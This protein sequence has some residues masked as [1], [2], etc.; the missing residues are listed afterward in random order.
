[1]P[2]ASCTRTKQEDTL[3]SRRKGFHAAIIIYHTP[4]TRLHILIAF[5]DAAAPRCKR[6]FHFLAFIHNHRDRSLS[7]CLQISCH[8]SLVVCASTRDGEP[9]DV[10]HR[11]V[12]AGTNPRLILLSPPRR[13]RSTLKELA[14]S[15]HVSSVPN[16]TPTSTKSYSDQYQTVQRSADLQNNRAISTKTHSDEQIYKTAHRSADLQNH[17]AISRSTKLHSDQHKAAQRSAQNRIAI[18]RSTKP[19][20]AIRTK[21]HSDQQIYK[22]AQRSADLRNRLQ[23]SVQNCTAMSRSTKLHSDQQIYETVYSDPYKTAQRSAD[24]RNRLQRSVQNCT[25]VSRSTKPHSD[26]QIYK[27]AQRSADVQN[28]TAIS[29]CTKRHSDQQ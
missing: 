20:T 6:Y 28:R 4:C 27:T 7:L 17:T 22:T 26:Q 12:M 25:A 18:S 11:Q 3:A 29:R 10:L 23:R 14:F 24:L 19:S 1:M 21:L 13:R 5:P 2:E 8:C 9:E 15:E 16:R